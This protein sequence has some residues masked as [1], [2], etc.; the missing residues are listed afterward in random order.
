MSNVTAKLIK[1]QY[2][3]SIQCIICEESVQLTDKEVELMHCGNRLPPKICD[4]CKKAI[5]YMRSQM[6]NE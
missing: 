4:K 6:P 1:P 2:T 3:Y 5:L